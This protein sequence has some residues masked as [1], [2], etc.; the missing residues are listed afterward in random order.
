MT[1]SPDSAGNSQSLYLRIHWLTL[2]Y[3]FSD[4]GSSTDCLPTYVKISDAFAR[5][6]PTYSKRP[7]LASASVCPKS[8]TALGSG[9]WPSDRNGRITASNSKPLAE[10]YVPMNSL[11]PATQ[12]ADSLRKFI[13]SEGEAD[14]IS[15]S[16]RT[17][18]ANMA[19][20]CVLERRIA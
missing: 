13:A 15:S 5:V 10:W 18:R 20:D 11:G 19:T 17:V 1:E 3:K 2:V 6:T 7:S 4:K 12:R 14:F 8:A 9:N 16:W